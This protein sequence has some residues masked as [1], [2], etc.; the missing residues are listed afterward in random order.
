MD[1]DSY[2][3]EYDGKIMTY[4]PDKNS[5]D[6]KASNYS[7]PKSSDLLTSYVASEGLESVITSRGV[8]K[9]LLPLEYEIAFKL[10]PR[11]RQAAFDGIWPDLAHVSQNTANV[12]QSSVQSTAP[13]K[14]N[15]HITQLTIPPVW[16][17]MLTAGTVDDVYNVTEGDFAKLSE[18]LRQATDARNATL[19]KVLLSQLQVPYQAHMSF[20]QSPVTEEL[21]GEP[22]DEDEEL[23]YNFFTLG[24]E[25][26]RQLCRCTSIQASVLR[27]DVHITYYIQDLIM[28]IF[29]MVV[30]VLKSKTLPGET[31]YL[32]YG[33]FAGRHTEGMYHMLSAIRI[34]IVVLH[35]TV[36]CICSSLIELSFE[37][38][39][40]Q[41]V[42]VYRQWK[43]CG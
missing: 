5:A 20:I 29:R 21:N 4:A 22:S 38:D 18:I 35:Q 30:V 24:T 12:I 32:S 28:R 16:Q 43:R 26:L 37:S 6:D 42:V 36:T 41:V 33:G 1:Q 27:E 13:E 40:L 11:L 23:Y 39:N 3:Y 25:F 2:E 19:C 7:P 15:I 14:M 17:D 10:F 9:P 34:F 31:I 8:N